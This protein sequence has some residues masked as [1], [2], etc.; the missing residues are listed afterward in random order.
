MRSLIFLSLV[1]FACTTPNSGGQPEFDQGDPASGNYM[2]FLNEIL[3]SCSVDGRQGALRDLFVS[4][5]DTDGMGQGSLVMGNVYF[6]LNILQTPTGYKFSLVKEDCTF[7]D[8]NYLSAKTCNSV[9]AVP[10]FDGEYSFE[11][12]RLSGVVTFDY[13]GVCGESGLDNGQSKLKFDGNREAFAT[14]CREGSF[15][16]YT[17]KDCKGKLPWCKIQ[18]GF[19]VA[20]NA[21]SYRVVGTSD[22]VNY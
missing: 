22:C 5:L 7:M 8:G 4:P 9:N 15:Y 13:S 12:N 6:G 17:E 18:E 2:I 21:K 11:T 20:W 19:C 3:N 10:T 14:V 16:C 1:C